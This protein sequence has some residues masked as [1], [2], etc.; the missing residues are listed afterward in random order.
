LK[1]DRNRNRQPDLSV[2]TDAFHP[3]ER[4]IVTGGPLKGNEGVVVEDRPP[5]VVV[6]IHLLQQNVLVEMD[7]D[8]IMPFTIPQQSAKNL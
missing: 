2:R 5:R 4:I 8:W 6:S 7:R 3:G 1:R